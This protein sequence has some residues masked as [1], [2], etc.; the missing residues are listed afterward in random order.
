MP[1]LPEV[2]T[3]RLGLLPI[4]GQRVVACDVRRRDVVRHLG[5][6]S[7]NN[8]KG[9]IDPQS[10]MIES[11]IIDITRVGKQL[12]IIV[13]DPSRH[14]HAIGLH[15]GMSGQVLL[16]RD[17][18][19]DQE[20]KSRSHVHVVWTLDDGSTIAFRD[21]RRFGKVVLHDSLRSLENDWARLGPD[22]ESISAKSL[23]AA[24]SST[25]RPIKAALLDQHVLAGVGNIYADEALFDARIHPLT[26]SHTLT[27]AQVTT[28]AKS[29]RTI[30]RRAIKARGSTLRDYRDANNEQGSAQLLHCVYSRSGQP[31][32]RCQT[33]IESCQIAQRTSCWC[34]KCQSIAY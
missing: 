13:Q 16:S 33:P 10:L 7:K 5:S 24:L 21:P 17:H 2:E 9:S 8:R 12:A 1:E 18:N 15:L 3:V 26:P 22:A 19:R 34:P 23:G 32:S 28:L 27:K 14:Q 30:L 6:T 4:V 11:T 20:I 25:S 29:I 31:C